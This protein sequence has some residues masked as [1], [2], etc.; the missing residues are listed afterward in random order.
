[1]K[2]RPILFSGPMVKAILEGRKT[3]T[4][5]V[6]KT[7]RHPFGHMLSVDDVAKEVIGDTGAVTCP[8]GEPGDR[9]WV[10]ETFAPHAD[11]PST[12]IYRCDPGGDYQDTV[13]PNFRWKPSIF[14]PRWASRITLEITGVRVE[15]LN[16][17]S[18]D[19]CSA[20][21][22]KTSVGVGLIDGERCFHFQDS[23]GYCRIGW[24]AYRELWESINGPGSWDANPWVWVVEFRRVQ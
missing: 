16:Q 4:R 23:S 10:K 5:R 24:I 3:Q 1:M 15:R 21:G 2:E 20:E 8:Y 19:D 13:T 12:A 14:M 9:L 17:I 18:D 6:V 22:I 7:Q 11:I